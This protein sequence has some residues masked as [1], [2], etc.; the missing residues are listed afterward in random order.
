MNADTSPLFVMLAQQQTI[1]TR[2]HHI[3]IDGPAGS[4]K[5][6]VAGLI[7]GIFVT[8]QHPKPVVFDSGVLF[9]A[10][11]YFAMTLYGALP[12]PQ[13][14]E[15]VLCNTRQLVFDFDTGVVLYNDNDITRVLASEDVGTYASHV[16]QF[17]IVREHLLPIRKHIRG[18]APSDIITLGRDEC[19]VFPEAQTKVFITASEAVLTHRRAKRAGTQDLT[20][21]ALGRDER[22]KSRVASPMKQHKD[23]WVIDTT[24]IDANEV[25]GMICARV[26]RT[27]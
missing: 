26:L 22:D 9:R 18:Q 5:T 4:G 16:A 11:G 24:D 25:A 10:I 12:S 8:H 6:T 13:E 2:S 3:A 7:Q 17:P 23:A 20:K 15:E 19:F 14:A 1:T 21:E 27:A